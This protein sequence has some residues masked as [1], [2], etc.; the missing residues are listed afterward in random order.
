[1]VDKYKRIW[2]LGGK[3]LV[4]EKKCPVIWETKLHKSEC[5][6]K[7]LQKEVVLSSEEKVGQVSGPKDFKGSRTGEETCKYYLYQCEKGHLLIRPEYWADVPI[8][9]PGTMTSIPHGIVNK[10]HEWYLKLSEEDKKKVWG[11]N[12]TQVK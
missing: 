1:M 4:E 9:P 3:K 10:P 7:I 2:A 5:S 11:Q 12:M 8:V 6:A